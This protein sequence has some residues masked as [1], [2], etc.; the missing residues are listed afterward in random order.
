MRDETCPAAAL[1]DETLRRV[2]AEAVPLSFVGLMF[3]AIALICFYPAIATGMPHAV[4]DLPVA[5]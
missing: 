4:K 2:L 1:G 3:V 5:R